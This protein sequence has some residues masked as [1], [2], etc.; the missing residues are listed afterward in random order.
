[1]QKKLTVTYVRTVRCSVGKQHWARMDR[2]WEDRAGKRRYKGGLINGRTEGE[3]PPSSVSVIELASLMHS[4][5]TKRRLLED[6]P[7]TNN[8][9]FADRFRPL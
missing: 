8:C 6:T 3:L 1:V 2:A 7:D 4:G 9:T 5:L